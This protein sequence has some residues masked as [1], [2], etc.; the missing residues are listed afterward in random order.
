MR[1]ATKD[2]SE[3]TVLCLNGAVALS[4]HELP[5]SLED[6]ICIWWRPTWL[7]APCVWRAGELIVIVHRCVYWSPQGMDGAKNEEAPRTKT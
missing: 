2:L 3:P 1:S 4:M 7:L 6:E 5:G